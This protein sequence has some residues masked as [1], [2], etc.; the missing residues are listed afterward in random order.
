[1]KTIK[2]T[3]SF[4][5]FAAIL[6]SV[7]TSYAQC[8][9]NSYAFPTPPTDEL[10]SQQ[11][12]LAI[13]Q[14]SNTHT[15]G[16]ATLVG[17]GVNTLTPAYMLDILCVPGTTNM[18]LNISNNGTFPNVVAYRIGGYRVLWYN[19]DT[20]SIYGGENTPGGDYP[21]IGSGQNAIYGTGAGSHSDV[22]FY[23]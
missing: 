20:S 23:S 2:L 21:V 16:S 3:L 22:M 9:G 8:W 5:S 19:N 10:Q 17:L 11:G 13:M 4:L 14:G 12:T 7:T 1:M 15:P 6:F 18:D